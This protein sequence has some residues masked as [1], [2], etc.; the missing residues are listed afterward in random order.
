VQDRQDPKFAR[1]LNPLSPGNI[2]A[3]QDATHPLK[4]PSYTSKK[5]KEGDKSGSG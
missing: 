1:W 5:R 2:A 3:P 4:M